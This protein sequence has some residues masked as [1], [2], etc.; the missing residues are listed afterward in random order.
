MT[1]IQRSLFP[2]EPDRLAAAPSQ[3]RIVN[4]GSPGGGGGGVLS[5]LRDL[6]IPG[7]PP[8]SSKDRSIEITNLLRAHE[9]HGINPENLIAE[10]GADRLAAELVY[11]EEDSVH[12]VQIRGRR[13]DNVAAL[14]VWRCRNWETGWR[15]A[16]HEQPGEN[17]RHP[18][19]SGSTLRATGTEGRFH[20]LDAPPG[21]W[22]TP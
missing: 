5:S 3:K 20:D 18:G 11:A 10:L 9:W 21:G 17:R 8:S 4:G 13:I 7:I 12:G 14:A 19:A 16:Q 22:P 15:E 2:D 6:K 1:G